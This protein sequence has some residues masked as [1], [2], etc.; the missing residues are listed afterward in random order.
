V[1]TPLRHFI[2]RCRRAAFGFLIIAISAFCQRRRFFKMLRERPPADMILMFLRIYLP[3]RHFAITPQ[4][5]PRRLAISPAIDDTPS[6]FR[7]RFLRYLL[8]IFAAPLSLSFCCRAALPQQRHV[9]AAAR[10]RL[11]RFSAALR[12]ASYFR[13][14]LSVQ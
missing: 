6:S 12:D 13:Q 10:R 11:C 3:Q 4:S 1:I 14:R 8:N 5:P 2:A 7:R 9:A